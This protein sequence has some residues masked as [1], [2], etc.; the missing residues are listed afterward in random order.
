MF[1][2]SETKTL[3]QVNK[4]VPEAKSSGNSYVASA[5]TKVFDHLC[6]LRGVLMKHTF[7]LENPR[8]HCASWNEQVIL[9]P[10][11][12]DMIDSAL[13]RQASHVFSSCRILGGEGFDNDYAQVLNLCHM[14]GQN[15][16]RG[17]AEFLM[18]KLVAAVQN[19]LMLR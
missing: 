7:S 15:Y 16:S 10:F 12:E 6:G 1:D 11:P 18:R 4:H 9:L 3:S 13:G 2:T 14:D 5:A 17:S 19:L 8:S